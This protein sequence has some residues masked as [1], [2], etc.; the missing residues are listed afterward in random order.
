MLYKFISE[1]EIEQA[2]PY[3]KEQ[4]IVTS[5]PPEDKL[6]ELGYKDLIVEPFPETAKDC[7]RLPIYI[8]GDVITQ[9]WSEEIK[10]GE[11]D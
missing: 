6:R 7:Y 10:D 8:D 1:T 4:G 9:K 2:P 3:I 5:N 11:N